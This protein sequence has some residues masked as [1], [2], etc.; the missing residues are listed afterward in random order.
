MSEPT[1]ETLLG[2]ISDRRGAHEA[3]AIDVD[4]NPLDSEEYALLVERNG[5]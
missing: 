5:A 3:F 4:G 2:H 1:P